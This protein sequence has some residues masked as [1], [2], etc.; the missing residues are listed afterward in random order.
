MRTR[1]AAA[2]GIYTHADSGKGPREARPDLRLAVCCLGVAL[3]A[4][5]CTSSMSRESEKTTAETSNALTATLVGSWTDWSQYYQTA[6]W[7]CDWSEPSDN[8]RASCMVPPDYALI[9]GGAEVDVTTS[10]SVAVLTGSYPDTGL[11]AWIA[12]SKA[13]L[14]DV[15]HRVRAYAIGLKVGGWDADTI[16]AMTQVFSS[17][18]DVT[19][20]PSATVSVPSDYVMLGGGAQAISS[21]AGQLLTDSRPNNGGSWL[22]ASKDHLVADPGT[23]RAYAIGLPKCM[24]YC[25]QNA[26]VTASGSAGTGYAGIYKFFGDNNYTTFAPTSVGGA[27]TYTSAG[28]LLVAMIPG[29]DRNMVWSK[30]Q[31]VVDTGTTEIDMLGIRYAGHRTFGSMTFPPPPTAQ[32]TNW[33]WFGP[34]PQ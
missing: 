26:G 17:T 5:A 21:G 32:D 1:N 22:A 18:S 29:R 6:A 10:Q 33:S 14:A 15:P 20:H 16:H 30:D 34:S 3:G 7:V 8:P 28:R 24:P 9:G 23:V 19:N 27:A 2:I 31:W 4:S 12:E 25:Q 13:H 11:V